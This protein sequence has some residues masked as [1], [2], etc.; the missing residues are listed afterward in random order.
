MAGDAPTEVTACMPPSEAFALLGHEHRVAILEALL[1]LHRTREE[2]PAS[3]S[4]L[5]KAAGVDV[6]SQFNYHLDA[7]VGHYLRKTTDGYEFRVAGWEV[8]TAILA[9]TYDRG[10][11]IEGIAADGTCPL[12]RSKALVVSYVEEWLSVEC[13]ACGAKLTSHPLAPG[14]LE[15]RTPDAFLRVFDRRVRSKVRLVGDGICPSCIGPMQPALGTHEP[16]RTAGRTAAYWC[17]RCGNRYFPSLGT[18][19]LETPAVRAFYRS[20]GEDVEARPHWEHRLCVDDGLVDV[21]EEDPWRCEVR[22]PLGDALV[23]ELDEELAIVSTTV[24][25]VSPVGNAETGDGVDR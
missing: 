1:S 21:L 23:V 11:R 24:E 15:G 8:A 18:F 2:Y 12:C 13:E 9:G 25:S 4:T 20:E 7:L 19:L 6:S 17:R 22:V 10:G 3:F 5:R 16:E 14:A